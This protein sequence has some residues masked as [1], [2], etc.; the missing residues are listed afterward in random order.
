MA[1]PQDLLQHARQMAELRLNEAHQASLRRALSSAYYALFHLL[2]G[3]A[4][5][6]CTDPGFGLP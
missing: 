6:N 5:A 3:D 1:Y 2:I 4:V